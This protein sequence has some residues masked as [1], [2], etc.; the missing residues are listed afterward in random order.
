MKTIAAMLPCYNEEPNVRPL[1]EKWLALVPAFQK[2]GYELRVFCIDD[3][4]TDQTLAAIRDVAERC[5]ERVRSIAHERNKGLGG[6]LN[7]A[8]D[9]FLAECRP[10][11][12][13]VLMDGDNTHDPVY[14]LSMLPLIND[15]CDCV[16]ASRY[17]ERS[18]TEGVPGVRL[19][20]SGGARLFYTLLLNIPGVKD[21]TCGYRMYTYALLQKARQTYGNGLV[22]RRSF[23]CMMEALYKLSLLGARFGEVPFELRYDH[24]Q[25]ES[26]MRV[27]KTVGESIGTAFSLRFQSHSTRKETDP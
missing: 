5:P 14:S 7:T 2:E 12:V 13:C 16:I 26:K 11:D 22:S 4:S 15:G 24:K 19:F 10:G 21:Y 6:A 25:G 8:F 23:A 3:K 18:R 20:L 1:V 27:L 17:C 9:T